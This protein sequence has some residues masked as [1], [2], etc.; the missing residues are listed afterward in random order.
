METKNNPARH[1]SG[2][3]RFASSGI[4]V[5]TLLVQRFIKDR[6][7]DLE[8]LGLCHFGS[9]VHYETTYGKLE[10]QQQ[11]ACEVWI[12][13]ENTHFALI[14]QGDSWLAALSRAFEA[15]EALLIE[16]Q[17]V[18]ETEESRTPDESLA[19]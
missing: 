18:S 8:G 2:S 6:I 11:L 9:G 15:L 1:V 10:M 5:D 19:A 12:S 4:D 7:D 14:G 13:S 3:V 16:S 17:H